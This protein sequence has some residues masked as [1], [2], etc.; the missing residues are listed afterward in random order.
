MRIRIH[1]DSSG[2][3]FP[4]LD[5]L[6]GSFAIRPSSL[7]EHNDYCLMEPQLYDETGIT[8]LETRKLQL[9]F[10]R[11]CDSICQVCQYTIIVLMFD[12]CE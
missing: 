10:N 2:K 12:Q 11:G 9:S 7:K 3:M 6:N 5:K 1:R 4:I 8:V